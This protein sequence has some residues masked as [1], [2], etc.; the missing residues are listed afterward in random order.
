MASSVPFDPSQYYDGYKE[1]E[2]LDPACTECLMK[3]KECFQH[4]NPKSSK[5]H[6]CFVAKKPY[7]FPGIPASNIKRY[8]WRK[9]DGPFGRKLPVSEAPNPDGTSEY[10]NLTDSKQREVY[11]WTN[12]G[13][14]IPAGGR[15]IYSTSE[16]PISII[17]TEGVVI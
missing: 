4:F 1:V 10:S 12:V 9:K 2:V 3:E 13:G 6:L 16:V 5:C 15:T 7:C 11:R 8:L 14:P 17:N